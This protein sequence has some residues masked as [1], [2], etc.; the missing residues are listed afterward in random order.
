MYT[1]YKLPSGH[2]TAKRS[3]ATTPNQ[4]A[5]RTV[6]MK[7]KNGVSR[8]K[9]WFGYRKLVA[10]HIFVSFLAG[11]ITLVNLFVGPV[12]PHGT[13]GGS[14]FNNTLATQQKRGP[15]GGSY[16]Q[17]NGEEGKTFHIHYRVLNAVASI[18]VALEHVVYAWGI[19]KRGSLAALHLGCPNF[20]STF[21]AGLAM[22]ITSMEMVGLDDADLVLLAG[23]VFLGIAASEIALLRSME[24]VAQASLPNYSTP[25]SKKTVFSH[26]G[27]LRVHKGRGWLPRTV[28]L[29]PLIWTIQ[30]I[31][32]F[33][34]VGWWI[35]VGKHYIRGLFTMETLLVGIVIPP[36]VCGYT[37]FKLLWTP[38]F[39][40]CRPRH[41]WLFVLV[42]ETIIDL[43]ALFF[44]ALCVLLDNTIHELY[45][46]TTRL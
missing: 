17:L 3:Q 15:K 8:A 34:F 35:F 23:M 44:V 31:L 43:A 19:H 41:R 6:D 5:Q 20:L 46:P 26:W 29:N 18:C 12:V 13:L 30:C 1:Q 33:V 40:V 10:F 32:F 36:F 27:C 38:M 16:I 4:G 28:E 21:G 37:V 42:L 7:G 14:S 39:H 9:G 24:H 22:H 45:H 11:T 25:T 2:H